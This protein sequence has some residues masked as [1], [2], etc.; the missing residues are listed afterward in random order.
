MFR[1]RSNKVYK[2]D[3]SHL[4]QIV[5][6]GGNLLDAANRSQLLHAEVLTGA[7]QVIVDF[8]WRKLA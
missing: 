4:N 8:A 5:G 3:Q 7:H 1:K 2:I 6:E